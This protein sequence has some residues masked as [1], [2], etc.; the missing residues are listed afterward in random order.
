M[1]MRHVRLAFAFLSLLVCVSVSAQTQVTASP[2]TFYQYSAEQDVIL[3]GTNIAGADH[4]LVLFSGQEGRDLEPA[5]PLD[6]N[7]ID[8]SVPPIVTQT[9]GTWTIEIEAYDTEFGTPRIYTT[10]IQVLP[11][12]QTNPPILGL[13][14]IV[15]AA[16]TSPSGA[17]VSFSVSAINDDGSPVP[18]TCNHNSGDLFPMGT[19]IVT[20]SAT[21]SFGTSTGG[22][23]V[24][25]SDLGVPVLNLPGSI[26]T[27]NPVVDFT[28]T[29]SDAIDGPLPVTCSPA[30]GSTFPLGTTFVQCHATDSSENTTYGEFS[31]T[32]LPENPP[33]SLTLPS[34]ITAEATSAAGAVVTYTVTTDATA[35]VAC[36]PPSG[37]TFALGTTTVNCTATG[38]DSQTTSGSFTVTVV[39]T[40]AP[41]ITSLTVTPTNLWPPDHTMIPVTVTATATDA[42]DP[43]PLIHIIDIQSNQ[44]VD[45]VDAGDAETSPDWQIT[46]ALTANLRAERT[47]GQDRIYTI[48]VQAVDA[49]DNSSWATVQV[50]VSQQSS[51]KSHAAH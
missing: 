42:V 23:F 22:F 10:S 51:G 7:T 8:I 37:S 19:T 33:P 38:A 12:P 4:T 46:G 6:A 18:V 31:V 26:V 16:A 15:A 29:A 14:E 44:P 49:S 41:R 20:C 39:D 25:V 24:V 35:T 40:T 43:N 2:S 21:N 11:I 32:I 13:P 50:K 1:P 47:S 5:E 34:N 36:T 45:A 27:T 30:S 17:N 28:P 48:I 9:T 3:T